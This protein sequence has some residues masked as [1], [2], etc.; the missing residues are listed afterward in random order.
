[1]SNEPFLMV[2]PSQHHHRH[3]YTKGGGVKILLWHF[4]SRILP[5]H[6]ASKTFT[7]GFC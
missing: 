6:F 3:E 1:M 7:I 4:T 5:V 2:T